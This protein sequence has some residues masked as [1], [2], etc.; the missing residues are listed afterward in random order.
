MGAREAVGGFWND[1]IYGEGGWKILR[2]F[3][4][5]LLLG[6]SFY[7]VF[8]FHRMMVQMTP[9]A[10]A[11]LPR[12]ESSLD[13][14]RARLDRLTKQFRTAVEAR[15][16][17]S[18]LSRLAAVNSRKPY[19][20]AIVI[21][22]QSAAETVAPIKTPPPLIIVTAVMEMAGE[23][24]AVADVE[25]LGEGVL[26]RPGFKLTGGKGRILSVATEKV[27][28]AWEGDRYEIPVGF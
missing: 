4:F 19:G 14:D 12:S 17:S 3:I 13:E 16:G 10:E 28:F 25:G 15:E 24:I 1:L 23:K 2:A 5:L 20:P 9:A 7:S 18:Q 11:F 22:K 8:V 21:S 6:G 27:V 26:I